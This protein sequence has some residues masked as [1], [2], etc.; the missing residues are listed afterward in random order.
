[1]VKWVRNLSFKYRILLGCLLVAL[2]PLLGGNLL[3]TQ[4]FSVSVQNQATATAQ[5]RLAEMGDKMD[6]VFTQSTRVLGQVADGNDFFSRA[7]VDN[8]GTRPDDVYLALYE[9]LGKLPSNVTLSLYDMG[10]KLRFTTNSSLAYATLPVH[11]GVLHKAAQASGPVQYSVQGFGT[12]PVYNFY[13]AQ[14]LASSTG[15]ATGFAVVGFPPAA[16]ADILGL[17]NSGNEVAI[18]LNDTGNLVYSRRQNLPEKT[19]KTVRNHLAA[20]N[21]TTLQ[22][23]DDEYY[24]SVLAGSGYYLLLQQPKILAGS[25]IATM[26]N[27]SLIM[28]LV[29][30]VLCIVFS[31][32]LSRGLARPISRLSRGMAQVKQGNLNVH[33][34]TSRTDELG[35]LTQNFNQMTTDLQTHMQTILQQQH[36]VDE[37]QIRLLQA[38]LNPHFLYN[39]LDTVKWLAKINNVPQIATITSNLAVILRRSISGG[40]FVTLQ[41][42]LDM[43][44]SYVDIQRIRFS[45]RFR[46][47]LDLPP[48]LAD[49]VIPK[50]ILQ[51]LVENAIMHGLEGK[52]SGY[53]YI[54]AL[55]DEDDLLISITDDG[56]GMPPEMIAELHQEDSQIVE[57]HLGL[58]NVNHI[59]R[60]NYG[61]QYGLSA[62]SIAGVGTT[63][64]VRLPNRKEAADG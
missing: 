45:G 53:I 22:L 55:P 7:M 39:T 61:R 36:E 29:S 28:A 62:H 44:Q 33:I 27:V 38:Q 25:T 54:Y 14:Q 40:N 6:L 52:E 12:T 26:R 18:L 5:A 13:M 50:L 56:C 19:L 42:E 23:G 15:M 46:Y 3:M 48:A 31:V 1:M 11:W 35:Q 49:S 51:P 32:L 20:A 2:L 4:L 9:A 58:Y 60:M 41:Q 24:P 8:S 37:S 16:F 10:G 47:V 43:I 64:T 21:A 63:I 59:V 34:S 30:L 57:G 17:Y